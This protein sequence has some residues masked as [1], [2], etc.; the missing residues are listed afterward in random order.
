MTFTLGW[1]VVVPPPAPGFDWQRLRDAWVPDDPFQPDDAGHVE[2]YYATKAA[3]THWLRPHRV[4]E[5]GVRAG[6]SALAMH[7]GCPMEML[8]GYDADEGGWGG[9][10]GYA[11]HARATFTA[12]RIEHSLTICDTQ[13]RSILAIGCQ[14]AHVDGDHSYD[15]A[16]HDITLCLR[17]GAAYVVVDDYAFAATVRAAADYAVR[18]N[19]LVARQVNDGYRGNLVIAN[20][21]ATLPTCPTA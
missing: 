10:R 2:R 7:M 8:Y 14:L 12:W 5:I 1:P 18:T 17:S 11:A 6:Y 21:H 3:I 13:L 9:V 15:G 19:G 20:T 4:L 16:L